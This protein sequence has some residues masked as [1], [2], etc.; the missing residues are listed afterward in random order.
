MLR[1]CILEEPLLQCLPS[2]WFIPSISIL[3]VILSL[4]N[5]LTMLPFLTVINS[6]TE[7]PAEGHTDRD[8]H[9]WYAGVIFVHGWMEA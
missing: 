4:I 6:L 8:R 5:Y 3:H 1:I 7:V 2:N 9:T